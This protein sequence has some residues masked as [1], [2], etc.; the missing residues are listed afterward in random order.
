[1]QQIVK[2]VLNVHRARLCSKKA[3]DYMKL[4]SVMCDIMNDTTTNTALTS[5]SS[6]ISNKYAIMEG[7]IKKYSRLKKKGKTHRSVLDRHLEDVNKIAR[8]APTHPVNKKDCIKLE[9]IGRLILLPLS[10][11]ACIIDLTSP[12]NGWLVCSL[13]VQRSFYWGVGP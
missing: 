3:R 5:E 2:G 9:M 13:T 8:S 4:Y 11:T 6:S 1:M 12:M 10:C 7:A